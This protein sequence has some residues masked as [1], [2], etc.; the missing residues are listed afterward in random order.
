MVPVIKEFG[1]DRIVVNSAADWGISDPLMIPRLVQALLRAGVAAGRRRAARL[2]QS[3]RASSRRA[4]AST[5]SASTARRWRRAA[6]PTTATPSCAARTPTAPDA[7]GRPDG[8]PPCPDRRGGARTRRC[9][10][11]R[12]RRSRSPRSTMRS[13]P[14][15]RSTRRSA[16][17][18]RRPAP[19]DARPARSTAAEGAGSA[20][21]A[22]TRP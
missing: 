17:T 9:R 7:R 20:R 6:R 11:R 1:V 22:H 14:A 16:T 3:R 18:W 4:A 15:R 21:R 19:A 12:D 8:P 5:P 13:R 2:G 10:T